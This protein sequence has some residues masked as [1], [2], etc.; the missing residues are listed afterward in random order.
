MKKFLLNLAA[1]TVVTGAACGSAFAYSDV[2]AQT[3]QNTATVAQNIAS[4]SAQQ[5]SP[6]HEQPKTRAQVYHELATAQRDGQLHYLY[7]NVFAGG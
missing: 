2:P 3:A 7:S 1:M 5:W 6:S 4:P